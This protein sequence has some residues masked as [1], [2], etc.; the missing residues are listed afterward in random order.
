M[1]HS[2]AP[3]RASPSALRSIVHP[4]RSVPSL[5]WLS[6]TALESCSKVSQKSRKQNRLMGELTQCV[7]TPAG[8]RHCVRAAKEMDS[9]SC[10]L[11]PQGLKSPR[12]R[13]QRNR[14]TTWR[15]LRRKNTRH[16]I[17]S[18]LSTELKS[19]VP[20]PASPFPF[21]FPFPFPSPSLP[22]LPPVVSH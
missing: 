10:G 20:R 19:P 5:N 8:R 1:R 3:V 21:P 7:G 13:L 15:E 17:V 11:C 12:C 16:R 14:D 22:S 18:N 9:K 6:L 2:S 4:S